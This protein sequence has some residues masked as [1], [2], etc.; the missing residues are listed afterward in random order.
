MIKI[1]FKT[2]NKQLTKLGYANYE[3]YL[4]SSLWNKIRKRVFV[5]DGG[6]CRECSMKGAVAHHWRYS[7]DILQGRNITPIVVVCR[8]CHYQLH[9]SPKLFRPRSKRKIRTKSAKSP[10]NEQK[11]CY[12]MVLEC[13]DMFHFL[14]GSCDFPSNIK[15]IED[16]HETLKLMID[17]NISVKQ[18][19]IDTDRVGD[20]K[21]W[22]KLKT[23]Y[24]QI[25]TQIRR[26]KKQKQ[27]EELYSLH[28]QEARQESRR[29][30]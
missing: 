4:S 10:E 7:L 16:M 17:G 26:D 12:N 3:E 1:D 14:L 6:R 24:R 22:R 21:Y 28:T 5:R 2:R 27:Q 30:G 25:Q 29:L 19:N 18:I 8:D 11:E 20:Y 23:R 13:C 15:R 9:Y